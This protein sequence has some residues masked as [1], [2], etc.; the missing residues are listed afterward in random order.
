MSCRNQNKIS[1]SS[2]WINVGTLTV[3]ATDFAATGRNYA[4]VEAVAA[5]TCAKFSPPTPEPYAMLIR[6]RSDG[7][8]NDDSILQV[9]AARGKDDYYK[10]AQLTVVQGQQLDSGSIYFVDTFT[11]ASEDALFDG[12]ESNL[13]D[14]IGHYYMRVLAC[15]RFAIICTDL[16]TTTVYIDICWLYE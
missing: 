15:D 16:D 8:E 7:S 4:T 13:T 11:P 3:Q 9:Y 5:T 14:M 6:C 2:R 1:L 12:E 10:I